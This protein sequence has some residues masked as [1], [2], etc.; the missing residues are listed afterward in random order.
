MLEKLKDIVFDGEK[1]CRKS[2]LDSA[3][4]I[5]LQY[6]KCLDKNKG[7]SKVL[8]FSSWEMVPRMVSVMLSYEAERLTIGKLFHDARFKRGRGYFAPQKNGVL[9]SQGF[10]MKQRR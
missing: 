9:V 1:W 7:Y 5:L 8:V 2:A 4:E 3:L 6:R 10:E